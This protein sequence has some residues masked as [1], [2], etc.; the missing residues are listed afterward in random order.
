MARTSPVVTVNSQ[1]WGAV[2]TQTAT[3]SAR[4]APATYLGSQSG[5][6]HRR[7]DLQHL[8]RPQ[9]VD[10]QDQG[11]EDGHDGHLLASD[12]HLAEDPRRHQGLPHAEEDTPHQGEREAGEPTEDGDGQRPEEH[13]EQLGHQHADRRRDQRPGEGGQGAGEG[14]DAG[15][16]LRERDAHEPG[17]FHVVGD[18]PDVDPRLGAQQH[19]AE[20]G[21]DRHED[22]QRGDLVDRDD[23]AE[24]LVDARPEDARDPGALRHD[25]LRGESDEAQEPG[26][27]VDRQVEA[28]PVP[29]LLA[30]HG[31]AVDQPDETTGDHHHDQAG[32]LPHAGLP[33]LG[34]EGT[35]HAGV[36]GQPPVQVGH[37]HRDAAVDEPDRPAH[38]VGH[39]QRDGQ[40]AVQAG[41]GHAQHHGR[42]E[43]LGMEF[44][45]DHRHGHLRG[46]DG[47]WA[48]SV[49]SD[50][51]GL[52]RVGC[53][54]ACVVQRPAVSPAVER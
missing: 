6:H 2:N 54:R 24:D 48:P 26:Q 43:E 41:G 15:S 36:V 23:T 45:S 3:A 47:S 46:C 11:E 37:E 28:G 14:V 53:T 7:L 5:G 16:D 29:H 40:Q 17:G 33:R 8:D 21:D 30:G 50:P 19:E 38:P 49:Q 4:T 44:D 12:R 18:R 27:R 20:H 51:P 10:E 1:Y 52:E 39:H 35:R 9:P 31:Q 32:P 34:N 25:Q 22:E 13:G 42:T